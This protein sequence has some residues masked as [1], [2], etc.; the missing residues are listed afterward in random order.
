MVIQGKI[1]WLT[2]HCVDIEITSKNNFRPIIFWQKDE[3]P[4][5]FDERTQQI[6]HGDGLCELIINK[7]TTKD[8]GNY[9]CTATNAIGSQKIVH[10]VEFTPQPSS[11]RDSGMASDTG[12]ESGRGKVDAAAA[13][14]G[15][16]NGAES[17]AT[18]AGKGKRPPRPKAEPAP[19]ETMSRRSAGPTFE[20]L[21]KAAKNKLS[22]VTHLTNRVF[23]EGTKVKLSC[24]VQGPDPNVR[25][26]KDENPVV[27]SP[28]VKNLSRDGMCV[29]EIDKCTPDDSGDYKL[30]V[31]NQDS[32]ISSGCTLQVYA[33]S[34]T[35]DFAPT[36][37]RALKSKHLFAT[38]IDFV[39]GKQLTHILAVYSQ[40]RTI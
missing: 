21:Q 25:W 37:T 35:S 39:V 10:K 15:V 12:S 2:V 7:P 31:R 32:D 40:I 33:A 29:L 9:A 18:E 38:E 23:A 22:F 27:Y 20:E 1:A 5:E 13:T 8:S 14:T 28:R 24:V 36:F 26:F 11:R 34:Q 19:E 16:A 4:I 6:E 17:S 3:L 30:V